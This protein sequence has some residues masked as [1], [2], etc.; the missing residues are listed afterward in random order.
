MNNQGKG[1]SSRRGKNGGIGKIVPIKI[2]GGMSAFINTGDIPSNQWKH[3]HGV[4]SS[5]GGQ[6]NSLK[7]AQVGN[8]TVIQDELGFASSFDSN[9]LEVAAKTLLQDR[10]YTV[11]YQSQN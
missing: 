2:G 9:E 5:T 4:A 10:G 7:I 1:S 8:S 11:S 6:V 3:C